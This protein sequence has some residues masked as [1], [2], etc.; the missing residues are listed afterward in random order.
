MQILKAND[1]FGR[2]AVQVGEHDTKTNPDCEEGVCAEPVQTFKPKEI[3]THK[4]YNTQ[5]FKHDIA[6]VRVED[7]NING[8]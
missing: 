1:V 8:E 6:L 3:I 4:D 7:I 2:A 5:P